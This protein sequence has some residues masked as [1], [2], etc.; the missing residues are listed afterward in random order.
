MKEAKFSHHRAGQLVDIPSN[1]EVVRQKQTSIVE[2]D[3]PLGFER[4]LQDL[5]KVK[6]FG[7]DKAVVRE[8]QTDEE[9]Y[10]MVEEMEE[11]QCSVVGLDLE[12]YPA[13]AKSYAGFLCLM[14]I[15]VLDEAKEL[16]T[17][18]VHCKKIGT[19]LVFSELAPIILENAE[20]LKVMHS[21][22]SNDVGWL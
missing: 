10:K 6:S 19:T 8:V 21:A 5:K 7:F 14:Q 22:T 4:A 15:T 2:E 11:F 20:V 3:E 13:G 16:V 17:Y 12:S 1:L 18:L 9:F